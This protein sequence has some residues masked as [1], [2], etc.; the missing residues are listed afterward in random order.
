MK[1]TLNQTFLL[2]AAATPQGARASD[3]GDFVKKSLLKRGLVTYGTRPGVGHMPNVFN[4][5]V[6]ILSLTEAGR[7]ACEGLQSKEGANAEV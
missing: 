5:R 1:L 4:R 2:L 6:L 7:L 3:Y